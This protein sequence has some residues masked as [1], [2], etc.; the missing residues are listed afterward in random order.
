MSTA[1]ALIP[2]PCGEWLPAV[3]IMRQLGWSRA[4]FFR[5]RG[6]LQ[7]R[8][9]SGS[10]TEYLLPAL[11]QRGTAGRTPDQKRSKIV[12]L[13]PLGPLFSQVQEQNAA[14]VTADPVARERY[15][16]LLPILEYSADPERYA[17]LTL[18]DGK[19]VT[20][21]ERMILYVS[22]TS[23]KSARTIKE[24]LRL[25]RDHGLAGLAEKQRSDKGVSR[26][27]QEH[28]L[29]TQLAEIA[30]YVH[31]REDLSVTM[32]H[33][34]IETRAAQLGLEA[35]SYSS[36]RRIL[37]TVNP[38]AVTLSRKG[39]RAYNQLFAPYIMRGF[40]DVGAGEVLVSDHM[41]HDV[42][43]QDDLFDDRNRKLIRL[44]FTGLEDM[45]S[46]RI[47]A[48]AWSQEGSS[49]SIVTVLRAMLTTHGK[50]RQLYCDNGKDYQKVSRGAR[51]SRWLI[52]EIPAEAM[53]VLARLNID[54]KHCIPFH[55]QAKMIERANLTI[56]QRFDKRWSSYCGIRPEFRP[57][58]CEKLMKHHDF[59]LSRDRVEESEI[60]LASEFIKAAVAWIEGEYNQVE[61]KLPGMD[62]LSP[63]EA[64]EKHRW[65][66][67]V[68]VTGADVAPLL[69]SRVRRTIRRGRI[70][71]GD[72]SYVAADAQSSVALHDHGTPGNSVMV[73]F[74]ECDE[75]WIAAGDEYGRIFAYLKP[76]T[77]LRQSD[78]QEN[79]DA[80]SAAM[81]RRGH[82]RKRTREQLAELDRRVLSTGYVPQKTQMLAIGNLPIPIDGLVVHRPKLT[83]S[84]RDENAVAPQT[85]EQIAGD[86][87]EALK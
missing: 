72:K 10:E 70:Q 67:S 85:A 87:L 50:F 46:R 63:V 81:E 71:I 77:P 24:W 30:A 28:P 2:A 6:E 11:P 26:W 49:R 62:G 21:K 58:K 3:E 78:D 18:A 27:V 76:D 59:L 86:I 36:I 45:R 48:Y 29:M 35:P 34:I 68:P 14:L 80:I 5:R 9:G 60:P 64:W 75:S 32:A 84:R 69:L 16:I 12:A 33:Q 40:V 38:A 20:S 1:R 41:I 7:Q 39:E 53:G 43:V 65:D 31:V 44:R 37:Q 15:N 4:T 57:E 61:R 47:P 54:V 51:G 56:H 73:H 79:R 83:R 74:D 82:L 8:V 55:P 25:F 52:D 22:A 13:T 23:G 19:P 17:R 42:F 66:R